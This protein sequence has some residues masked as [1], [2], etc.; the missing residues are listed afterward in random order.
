M[1]KSIPLKRA[2]QSAIFLLIMLSAA[3]IWPWKIISGWQYEGEL[4]K[5][6]RNVVEQE[7]FLLQEFVPQREG[8]SYI[9]FYIYNEDIDKEDVL[10]FRIYEKNNE[11]YKKIENRQIHLDKLSFPGILKVRIASELEPGTPYYFSIQNTGKDL[12]LSKSVDESIDVRYEYRV[13]FSSGQYLQRGLTI[14]FSGMLLILLTELIFYKNQKRVRLDF[15]LRL[16]AGILV[17]A[18]SVWGMY[19]V[20]PGR[21]FSDNWVDNLFYEAGI[22]LFWVFSMY[23]LFYRREVSD[24][25]RISFVKVKEK[26]PGVLQA[27]AFAG[28]MLGCVRYVNALNG[29]EQKLA[30]NTVLIYFALAIICGYAKK[31]ILNWYNLVYMIPA[32]GIAVNYCL[33]NNDHIEH[34]N[35]AKGSAAVVVLWGLVVLNTIRMLIKNKIRRVSIIYTLALLLLIAEMVRSRNTRTWPI[36]IAVFWGLFAVR[37][38]YTGKVQQYLYNFSNGVFV[39]FIGISIYAILYRP[40]HYYHYTR[41]PGVFHTVTMTAVYTAMVLMLAMIRFL[42]V[43]KKEGCLKKAWKELW[44]MGMAEAFLMLT[45]SR[46]G[47]LAA[48]VL[49]PVLLVV[50]TVVE[51]RDGIKGLLKRTALFLGVGASFFVL[52]FT[53]CRIVPAVVGQPFTYVIEWFEGSVRPGEEWDSEWFVTVPRF[54]GVTE[55]RISYQNEADAITAQ[56]GNAADS[57]SNAAETT[58]VTQKQPA[59][60]ENTDY[61]NGRF[62]IYKDYL[63]A[64]NWKGHD[65]LSLVKENGEEI[66]HAHNSFIQTAYDFG[67]GEGI[68]FLIFCI[69][70]GVKSIFYYFSHKEEGTGPVPVMVLGTF[71]ICGMVERVFF[72]YISLGFAFL[73]VLVLFI[74]AE[75]KKEQI[76]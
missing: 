47:L 42:A 62:D 26:L 8:L 28:T 52:I 31:E 71:G 43:Y 44:V 4:D 55:A 33:K 1:Q 67:I 25:D 3:L 46:T 2:V 40:F 11:V 45:I 23:G 75:K 56:P 15:G 35:V 13:P 20:F 68:Y 72:P 54:F 39:H 38:A 34:W 12:L 63:K 76:K 21:K 74:P 16:A 58:E 51:F 10:I 6:S 70:A 30:R 64:L 27:A 37:V 14:L 18:A 9:S 41:Y 5:E 59:I 49:C 61:S 29:Y 60:E 17:S 57:Q 66:M 32:I 48:V 65:S 69:F 53:A 7:G 22:L 24:S 19:A 36:E 50:T 73:F